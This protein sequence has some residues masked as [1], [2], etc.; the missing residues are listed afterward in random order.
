VPSTQAPFEEVS[1]SLPWWNKRTNSSIYKG[2]K[3]P[4][5]NL[6]WCLFCFSKQRMCVVA[7]V[8]M[9]PIS[10]YLW[11]L[12]HQGVALF[13]K[14]WEVWLCW[15]KCGLGDVC[16]WGWTLRS[17]KSVQYPFCFLLFAS[18]SLF[19]LP[20]LPLPTPF[21]PLPSHL[22]PLPSPLSSLSLSHFSLLPSLQIGM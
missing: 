15:N 1:I 4:R 5:W 19:P 14:D 21:S 3:G 8:R 10:S 13:E 2:Y 22:S 20:S 17:E 11:M 6:A 7:W 16:T 12:R 9:A 18:L